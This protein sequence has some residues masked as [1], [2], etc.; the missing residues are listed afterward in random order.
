M[1]GKQQIASHFD[2]YADT[3]SARLKAHAYAIRYDVVKRMVSALRPKVALDIGCGTGDYCQLF[4]PKV[5]DYV[6]YDLSPQM[7]DECRR[8]YPAYRFE[9]ADAE[10]IPQP[11]GEA[12]LTLDIAV[13]EYYNDPGP[14]FAELARVTRNQGSI[15]VAVPNASNVTRGPIRAAGRLI[16]SFTGKPASQPGP[17]LHVPQTLAAMKAFGAA[18][19]LDLVDYSYCC[20]RLLPKTGLDDGLS[21]AISD[22]PGWNWITRWATTILVCHYVK[23]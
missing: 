17:I 14:H 2:A 20:V 12:D 3:W 21:Q 23:H 18:A 1:S 7:I 19:G 11:D 16:G 6:G 9:V 8:L 4:D 5:T 10:R 22:K 13:I 15:V